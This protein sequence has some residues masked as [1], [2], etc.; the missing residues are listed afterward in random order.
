[1][2]VIVYY[3]TTL[4]I[5]L[6]TLLVIFFTCIPLQ[7]TYI[8]PV[9]LRNFIIFL[10]LEFF[11]SNSSKLPSISCFFLLSLQCWHSSKQCLIVSF[12]FL[13]FTLLYI[14]CSCTACGCYE[15]F[16]TLWHRVWCYV[17]IVLV[18][19]F[20]CYSETS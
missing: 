17:L 6:L 8:Y 5:L 2:R 10:T 12:W 16:P 15:S 11:P 18:S 3:S 7:K 4:L 1:M 13:H 19:Y 14:K 9:S 20:L